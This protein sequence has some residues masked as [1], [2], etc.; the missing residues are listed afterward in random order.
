[1]VWVAT[2]GIEPGTPA[3]P[4]TKNFAACEEMQRQ[5]YGGAVHRLT[6]IRLPSWSFMTILW[7]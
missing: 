3:A 7:S 1:V 5:Q 4:P 2:L 6:R